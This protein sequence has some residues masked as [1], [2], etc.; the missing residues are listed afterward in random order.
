MAKKFS[1]SVELSASDLASP[2]V[3]RSREAFSDFGVEVNK[4]L[5]DASVRVRNF[6]DETQKLGKASEALRGL[7]AQGK[8]SADQFGNAMAQVAARQKQ[9]GREIEASKPQVEGFGLTLSGL[10]QRIPVLFAGAATAVVVAI[11]Q[12][13]SAFAEWQA[14]GVEAALE[15]EKALKGL[16]AATFRFGDAS[17]GIAAGLA[18]QSEALSQVS[19]QSRTAIIQAQALAASMAKTPDQIE[20]VVAAAVRLSDAFGG[21]LDANTRALAG[22]LEGDLSKSLRT[23]IPELRDFS[24]SQLESGEAIDL[25]AERIPAATKALD[26]YA[27]AVE[28]VNKA[29][30][31]N[32]EAAGEAVKQDA[33]VVKLQN[34]LA[35]A[36]ER[37]RE[38]GTD[39]AVMWEKLKLNVKLGAQE[40]ATAAGNL[41]TWNTN[42]G[43]RSTRARSRKG[44]RRRGRTTTSC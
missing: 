39:L 32:A 8:L 17:A 7:F 4:T 20:R 3:R 15:T 21:D 18:L 40:F 2:V 11:R 43:P 28:R 38:A 13:V 16:N 26:S 31:D 29:R 14:R 41:F 37:A 25:V 23:L 24:Q 27:A 22:T 35:N 33:E 36:T 9:L 10:A 34:Q 12:M 6:D 5:R 19:G 1:V 30:A 42:A 44:P